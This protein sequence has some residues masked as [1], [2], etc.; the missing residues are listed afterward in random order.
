MS[1]CQKRSFVDERHRPLLIIFAPNVRK[2]LAE[3]DPCRAYVIISSIHV[4]GIPRVSR[5]PWSSSHP[6]FSGHPNVPHD[7]LVQIRAGRGRPRLSYEVASSS[8]SARSVTRTTFGSSSPYVV[9]VARSS[10]SIEIWSRVI[11]CDGGYGASM[12]PGQTG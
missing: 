12:A 7:G 10:G 3:C 6:P 4:N 2:S 8:C 1:I 5:R 11:G 9:I